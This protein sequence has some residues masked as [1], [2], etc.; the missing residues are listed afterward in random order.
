[1]KKLL[2]SI[3]MILCFVL[4]Y[5]QELPTIIPP[6]PEAVSLAKFIETPVSHYTGTTNVTIPIYTIKDRDIEIPV[7]LNYHTRGVKVEEVAS[8]VGLGWALNYGGSIS[9]QIRGSADESRHGYFSNSNSLKTFFSDV[10]TRNYV[11]NTYAN[12]SEYDHYPDKFL[13][14]AN[15]SNGSFIYDYNN[16]SPLLQGYKDIN[17]VTLW[18][19]TNATRNF[20][21]SGFVV[22]DSKGVKYYYGIS[23]DGS[24][25]AISYSQTVNNGKYLSTTNSISFSASTSDIFPTSWEL[26]DVVSP[27]GSHVKFYY[28]SIPSSYYQKGYDEEVDNNGIETHF[29]KRIN[30]ENQLKEIHFNRGKLFFNPSQ[31]NN[32]REDIND[33]YC[34]DNV[35]LEDLNKNKIKETKL[36]YIYTEAPT[37]SNQLNHLRQ[38]D[39]KASKRMFLKSVIEYDTKGVSLP[40]Y[41]FG[42]NSQILPSRFSTSQDVW[43]N[44]NGANN[45]TQMSFFDN[46]NR[47]VDTIKSQAGILE[48]ITNP[49]GGKTKLIY[50]HNRGLFSSKSSGILMKAINPELVKILKFTKKDFIFNTTSGKYELNNLIIPKGYASYR[51]TCLHFQNLNDPIVYPD[52]VFDFSMKGN[53]NINPYWME[54]GKLVEFYSGNRFDSSTLNLPG[55]FS[56]WAHPKVIPGVRNPHKNRDFDFELRIEYLEQIKGPIY[57]EGKRIK[58]IEKYNSNNELETGKEYSYKIEDD[59]SG[60]INGFPHFLSKNDEGKIYRWGNMPGSPLSSFNGNSIGYLRVQEYLGSK[61]NNKGKIKYSF[62]FTDDGGSYYEFPYHIPNSTEWLRGKPLRIEY[63]RSDSNEYKLQKKIENTYLYGNETEHKLGSG[64][65][66]SNFIFK[67]ESNTL[68]LGTSLSGV[69]N[70][71]TK[72]NTLFRMPLFR[73]TGTHGETTYKVYYL[74]GGTVDLSKTEE[75]NYF[76]SGNLTSITNYFYDYDKH[77]QL[78]GSE[79]TNSKGKSYKTNNEYEKSLIPF[80]VLPS[81][82]KTYKNDI[83]LSHQKTVY[84]DNHN[85]ANLYLPSKVQ[86]SKGANALEDRVVYHSYDDKGNPTEV[87]KK[88]GTHLVYIWGYHQTQPIAKIENAKLLDIPVETITS[89]QRGSNND[90]DTA[91]ETTLRTALQSLR[92]SLPDAQVTTY[93][94][95]PL[96]GITSI[97]DPRGQT[98]YYEYDDFNRLH[99]VKD[100]DKNILKENKYNYKN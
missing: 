42:Y 75:T 68:P 95:D 65:I 57:A 12:H 22:T 28:S 37:S 47:K 64:F 54:T 5:A 46:S 50:E 93:T 35:V 61:E 23:K 39:P 86:T 27:L 62:T 59:S 2:L 91:S 76:D 87:S 25:S 14:N 98:I 96:I 90:L 63:Y 52:C 24:R 8:R 15:G 81:E 49:T 69:E 6:S 67:P 78:A 10:D 72:S 77:Y 31:L 79:T 58:R 1:M 97:T 19:H 94:Y 66:S 83:L 53:H 51:V 30:Y 40:G 43:G 41:K 88:D 80:R 38:I 29:N 70:I 73:F 55:T 45:G 56:F 11:R 4:G 3:V 7:A 48:E 100:K 26:M 85:P 60:S 92:V 34:L 9:R 18:N 44:Y 21:V 99:L 71:Y 17:I 13:F 82:T 16:N 20:K 84:T 74:T 89:L 32:P 36:N 33:G